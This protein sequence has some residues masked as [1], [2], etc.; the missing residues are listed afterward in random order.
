MVF[1]NFR[2]DIERPLGRLGGY[3]CHL[4]NSKMRPLSPLGKKMEKMHFENRSVGAVGWVRVFNVAY[5]PPLAT[6]LLA[7]YGG[8]YHDL[9]HLEGAHRDQVGLNS[10]SDYP[11]VSQ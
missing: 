1:S 9:R 5:S 2:G 8:A 7:A 3:L 4:E 6:L 11:T 10:T